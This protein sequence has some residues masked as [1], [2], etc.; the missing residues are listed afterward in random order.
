M[1]QAEP[2][3][4]GGAAVVGNS[5]ATDGGWAQITTLAC[6]QPKPIYCFEQ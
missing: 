4:V 3:G 6:H 2:H 1:P 5:S